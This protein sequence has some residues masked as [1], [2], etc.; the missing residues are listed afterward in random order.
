MRRELAHQIPSLDGLRAISITLVIF[1]HAIASKGF[2]GIT[3]VRFL[4][5]LSVL[6]VTVFFVISGFLVY[7][8][9]ALL[10]HRREIFIQSP[11]KT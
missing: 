5:P 10:L 11:P 7:V 9:L 3:A 6:G 2:I 1:G 8:R 4:W